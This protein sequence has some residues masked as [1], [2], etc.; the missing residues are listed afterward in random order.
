MTILVALLIVIVGVF[1]VWTT[2]VVLDN[3]GRERNP[4][5][6]W[7]MDR[8]PKRWVVIK[9]GVHCALAAAVIGVEHVAVTVGGVVF[10]LMIGLVVLWNI[11]VYAKQL[12]KG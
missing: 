4:V 8:A 6:K 3:G 12:F 1:D 5:M 7:L 9:V 11:S 2:Q 10:A